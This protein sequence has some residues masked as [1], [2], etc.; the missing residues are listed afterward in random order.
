MFGD[1]QGK[2]RAQMLAHGLKRLF[3]EHPEYRTR[4]LGQIACRLH[5]GQYTPFVP[6]EEEIDAMMEGTHTMLGN[7]KTNRESGQAR[8]WRTAL[9]ESM[10]VGWT[11]I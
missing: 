9:L 4:R 3:E 7:G 1:L 2:E 6:K 11:L 10:G 8:G 5:M